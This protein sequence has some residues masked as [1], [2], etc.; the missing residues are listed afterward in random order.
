MFTFVVPYM[1]DAQHAN[2]GVKAAY[3]FA[4]GC[5]ISLL[6]V[7]FLLPEVSPSLH[8]IRQR[9]MQWV[10]VPDV[11]LPNWTSCGNLVFLCDDSR[12]QRRL[13]TESVPSS[14]KGL[15]V[16]TFSDLALSTV[17]EGLESYFQNGDR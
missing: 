8:Q 5:I 17:L 16:E 1:L 9:L 15:M 11:P 12:R 3:V 13:L 6:A 7:Y 10:R 2:W 4:G 14:A